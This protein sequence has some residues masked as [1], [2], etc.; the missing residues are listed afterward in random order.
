M[1]KKKAVDFGLPIFANDW[2]WLGSQASLSSISS[3]TLHVPCAG[4]KNVIIK[5]KMKFKLRKIACQNGVHIE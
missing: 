1:E 2:K 3:L 4:K 5:T